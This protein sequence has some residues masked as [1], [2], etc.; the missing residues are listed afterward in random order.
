MCNSVSFSYTLHVAVTI[1]N[2][3]TLLPQLYPISK[4]VFVLSEHF[5]HC[6]SVGRTVGM[7]Q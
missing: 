2:A 1:E 5:I 4:T 7:S 3:F 6:C